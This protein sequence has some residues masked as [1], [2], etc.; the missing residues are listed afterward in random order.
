MIPALRRNAYERYP[1]EY[2]SVGESFFTDTTGASIRQLADDTGRRLGKTFTAQREGTGW[3]VRRTELSQDSRRRAYARYPWDTL[4]PDESFFTD[5]AGSGIHILA[6]AASNRLKRVFYVAREGDGWRVSRREP[7]Q[8]TRRLRQLNPKIFDVYPWKTMA[9]GDSFPTTTCSVDT[10][11]PE[12]GTL[13]GRT[14][15]FIDEHV[16]RTA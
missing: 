7:T 11:C 2:L 14:F 5:T 13:L 6:A 1:W 8:A 4:K 3:R 9:V 12:I 16:W 10:L 15:E